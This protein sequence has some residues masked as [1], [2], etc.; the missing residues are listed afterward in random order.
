MMEFGLKWVNMGRYELILKLGGALWLTILTP[1]RT[2][3][4]P[5]NP[6]IIQNGLTITES[7]EVASK[8]RLN[9][10]CMDYSLCE[11]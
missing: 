5:T 6:K 10:G 9:L 2:R 11:L 7:S 8:L 1:K 3:E 4:G